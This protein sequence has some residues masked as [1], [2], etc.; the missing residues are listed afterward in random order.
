MS[1]YP[2]PGSKFA[3]LVNGR[4]RPESGIRLLRLL[5]F[6]SL[7][8]ASPLQANAPPPAQPRGDTPAKVR[9][10]N[11][12]AVINATPS[13]L[14]KRIADDGVSPGTLHLAGQQLRGLQKVA[15]KAVERTELKKHRSSMVALSGVDVPPG[16]VFKWGIWLQRKKLQWH[17]HRIGLRH[18]QEQR[19]RILVKELWRN[20]RTSCSEEAYAEMTGE[21]LMAKAN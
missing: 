2:V 10:E 8:F 12:G 19:R 7:R 3:P 21:A 9:A 5:R 6:A 1:K 11:V 18:N 17:S 15:Q 20:E 4:N 14:R 13:G 16:R